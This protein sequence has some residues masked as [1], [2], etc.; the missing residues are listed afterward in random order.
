MIAPNLENLF[1]KAS[2][3]KIQSEKFK[4]CIHNIGTK[5]VIKI[6]YGSLFISN[7]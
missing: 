3:G 1:S 5:Y 4:E 2:G 6:Y 7:L